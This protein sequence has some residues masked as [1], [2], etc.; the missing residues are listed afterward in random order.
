ME[1][2]G[3]VEPP[4]AGFAVRCLAVRPHV[5][6]C[7]EMDLN[8]QRAA[9]H[10]AVLRWNYRCIGNKLGLQ[11]RNR[12][13]A[14]GAPNAADRHGPSRRNWWRQPASNRRP[15]ACKAGALPTE[16]YPLARIQCPRNN[17]KTLKT[18]PSPPAARP[19]AKDLRTPAQACA[20]DWQSSKA[21]RTAA[22]D[23]LSF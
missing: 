20:H 1:H 4:K 16:L 8:H 2:V 12:T 18:G 17:T 15:S 10:A 21:A 7:I 19:M 13:C 5:C 11:G 22:D 14:F 6:W 23:C 3:G 9:F